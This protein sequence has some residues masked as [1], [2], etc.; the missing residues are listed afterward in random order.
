LRINRANWISLSGFLVA[1]AGVTIYRQL[2]T[3]LE[4]LSGTHVYNGF[5]LASMAAT[6]GGFL[7]ALVGF[8]V[9]A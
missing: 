3:V 4:P 9:W 7:M 8:V 1:T 6:P 5:A 2:G